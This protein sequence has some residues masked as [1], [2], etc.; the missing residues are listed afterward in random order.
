MALKGINTIVESPKI[1]KISEGS[2]LIGAHLERL[3]FT[4]PGQILGFPEFGSRVPE[5]AFWQP[6]NQETAADIVEEIEDV[7]GLYEP[8]IVLQ[9][10]TVNFNQM[11]GGNTGLVIIIEW[12]PVDDQT[13]KYVAEFFRIRDS[14]IGA[15]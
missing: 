8:R 5:F 15:A 10:I 2:E 6:A 4:Q 12:S 3:L 11:S 7:I 14:L 13:Q 1:S 9:N